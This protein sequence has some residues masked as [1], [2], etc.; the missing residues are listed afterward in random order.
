MTRVVTTLLLGAG[1]IAAATGCAA[2]PLGLYVGAGVGQS[3]LRQDFYQIDAHVT[4]W[5]LLA[6]WRPLSSLGAELEYADLGRKNVTYA[7]AL[8]TSQIATSAKATALF[9]VGYLPLP[10]PWLDIYG[11]LG[12]AR[13]QSNTRDTFTGSCPTGVPC[14]IPVPTV[15]VD[16]TTRTRFA[17]G[18]GAQLKFG[19]PGVR[20]EYERF[21]GAQGDQ[22]LLSLAVTA[23]F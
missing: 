19:V 4:G 23:S 15:T 3:Q 7:N 11:K 13:L 1:A 5:K 21:T 2:D 22:A 12:A 9:A 6:G 17:F 18:A 16:D 10:Q 8:G 20:L 14:L